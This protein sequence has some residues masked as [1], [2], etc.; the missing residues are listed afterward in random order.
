MQAPTK[1]MKMTLQT[2]LAKLKAGEYASSRAARNA[3]NSISGLSATEKQSALNSITLHDWSH[4]ARA[5][6]PHPVP[7]TTP[8]DEA[9]KESGLPTARV[10]VG[11]LMNT[12]AVIEGM[13]EKLTGDAR[14]ACDGRETPTYT[15]LELTHLMQMVIKLDAITAFVGLY[16][17]Y[18]KRISPEILDV[19]LLSENGRFFDYAVII[20]GAQ[21]GNATLVQTLMKYITIEIV[22]R[23]SDPKQVEGFEKVVMSL[24][25]RVDIS[26]FLPVVVE[27]AS[28]AFLLELLKTMDVPEAIHQF[29]HRLQ[30][31]YLNEDTDADSLGTFI[32][33][34]HP[35]LPA[36]EEIV[37]VLFARRQL[38][39]VL[40]VVDKCP[41]PFK[42][43]LYKLIHPVVVRHAD[44]VGLVLFGM[45]F[46]RLCDRVELKELIQR[47]FEPDMNKKIDDLI[48]GIDPNDFFNSIPSSMPPDVAAKLRDDTLT[49][50]GRPPARSSRKG[51]SNIPPFLQEILGGLNVQAQKD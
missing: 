16:H 22:D 6:R 14:I 13:R 45:A 29:G 10:A 2:F 31:M 36:I 27:Y 51:W 44:P 47:A 43:S 4:E 39:D 41:S 21:T 8:A 40:M 24:R 35:D 49:S 15:D 26:E 7:A 48:D 18:A 1:K 46:P 23:A 12:F 33:E 11:S 25:G 9:P 38:G 37:R 28:P 19:A 50:L 32:D 5:E 42:A 20:L 30:A 34:L 3:I 17:Y